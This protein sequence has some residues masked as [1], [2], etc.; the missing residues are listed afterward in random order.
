VDSW[1][2]AATCGRRLFQGLSADEGRR[3]RRLLY[4]W[5]DVFEADMLKIKSEHEAASCFEENEGATLLMRRE[6]CFENLSGK[7]DEECSP[8]PPSPGREELGET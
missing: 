8:I 7:Q 1:F 3:A 2:D 4:T 6:P 5:R